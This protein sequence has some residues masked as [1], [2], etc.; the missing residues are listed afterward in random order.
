MNSSVFSNRN[1]SSKP[2]NEF[3]I[4][5]LKP[6]DSENHLKADHLKNFQKQVSCE[7]AIRNQDLS[8]DRETTPC[9]ISPIIQP[10]AGFLKSGFCRV[11]YDVDSQGHTRNIDVLKCTN[12]EIR[13]PSLQAVKR[14][15]FFPKVENGKTEYYYERVTKLEVQVSDQHGNLLNADLLLN[16]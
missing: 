7:H 13:A 3:G 9:H 8:V 14:W 11:S 4:W 16:E 1:S 15:R 5:Q 2:E 6:D 12:E 10:E